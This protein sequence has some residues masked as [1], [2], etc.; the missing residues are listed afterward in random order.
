MDERHDFEQ[1][2]SALVRTGKVIA[3]PATPALAARV[4]AQ[5]VSPR[6][7]AWLPRRAFIAIVALVIALALLVAIP[8]TRE[9]LA[10]ILGLRTIR[11]IPVTPTATPLPGTF[12]PVTATPRSQ[13]LS[14][15]PIPRIQ[16]CET[17][18]ADAQA[19][20]RF[21]V[22]LP[23]DQSPSRVYFQSLPSFGSGAQQVILIFGDPNVPQFT[24]YQATNIL[25][26]KIAQGGTVISESQVKGQRALW[27]TGALHVLIVQ[28]SSGS[29]EFEPERNVNLNT[30]GWEIGTV[31]FRVETPLSKEQAIRFAESLQ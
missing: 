17:T 5:L 18:L 2:E 13:V 31:T 4:Q 29:I 1:L 9:A 20:S 22:L 6:Q 23:P 3:Y 25:Y 15:T 11:I 27:L 26:M 8:E 14:A 19:K 30:L 7:T 28:D 12:Q 16:C 21:K 24:L 10:Q